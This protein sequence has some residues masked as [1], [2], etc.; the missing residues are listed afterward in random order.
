MSLLSSRQ[1]LEQLHLDFQTQRSPKDQDRDMT[2]L[3]AGV[4]KH[5]SAFYTLNGKPSSCPMYCV[6]RR[7]LI[8]FAPEA[9]QL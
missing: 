5:L 9:V 1:S 3:V 7:I 2:S 8:A 4:K 6:V